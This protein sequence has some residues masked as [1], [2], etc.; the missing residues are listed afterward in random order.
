MGLWSTSFGSP[1]AALLVL[2]RAGYRKRALVGF[3]NLKGPSACCSVSLSLSRKGSRA[4][5]KCLLLL[6][7]LSGG[8]NAQLEDCVIVSI[9]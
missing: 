4:G 7:I 1:L 2:D 3:K 5:R 6:A 8:Q 9:C